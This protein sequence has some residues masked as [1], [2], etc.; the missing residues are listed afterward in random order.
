MR[1]FRVPGIPLIKEGDD[2]GEI[3]V[4]A[5]RRAGMDLEDGDILVIA[6]TVVSKAEGR[7]VRLEEVKPSERALR[8]AGELGK[9]PREVEVVLRNSER[10]VRLGRGALITRTPHGFVCANAGVD[11]SNA[12]EG[13]LALL[14]E[15]PDES[16]RRIRERIRELT[17]REVGVIISDSWGRTFRR[18]IV[19]HAIGVSGIRPFIDYRGRKDLYG[20]VLRSKVA[21]VV[22]ALA[23]AAVLLMGEADEGTPVVLVRDAPHERGEST[24]KE[25]LRPEEED[26]FIR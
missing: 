21:C 11:A 18:G 16:A 1:L 9:D 19:G 22:D 13:K 14:P 23:A 7:T 5:C 25:V 3:V 2:I 20:R 15:D 17:G 10:I 12:G 8:L 26:L 6:Q 24:I 4:D